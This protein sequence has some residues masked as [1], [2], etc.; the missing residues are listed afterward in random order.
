MKQMASLILAGLL[1]TSVT[2]EG[3]SGQAAGAD[4]SKGWLTDFEKA[5]TEAA[6]LDQPIFAFFTGS[7]WCGWCMKLK[8]EVLDTK[9]FKSFAKDNLVLFEAD[10]P[11]QK[12]IPADVKKQNAELAAKYGVRGYPSV[13]LLDAEGKVLAQTGYQKGGDKAY[14]EHL[15]QL[16]KKAGV[17]TKATTAEEKVQSPFEKLKAAREAEAAAAKAEKPADSETA[18]KDK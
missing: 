1:A 9:G 5:K 16:L 18:E 2:A 12:K 10:F 13:Y 4:K 7:D 11:Q 8:G 6:A 3:L 14:V 17:G 15:Q